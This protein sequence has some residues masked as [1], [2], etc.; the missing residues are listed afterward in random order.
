M[1]EE[2]ASSSRKLLVR[3]PFTI[4][5]QSYVADAY[6]GSHPTIDAT[7]TLI[8]EQKTGNIDLI[9][10][11]KGGITPP[12]PPPVL[13]AIINP[14][15]QFVN[16]ND[17]VNLDGT[18]S[19]GKIV[20]YKWAQV[21]GPAVAIQNATLSI[22]K[23]TEPNTLS[24][25]VVSLTVADANTHTDTTTATIK[26]QVIPPPGMI[27]VQ[28]VE[29]TTPA[30]APVTVQLSGS[31]TNAGASSITLGI[32]S[33]PAHGTANIIIT[34]GA[35]TPITGSVSAKY[36]PNAGFTGT[37]TFT[38][39]ASDNLG[40]VSKPG[41]VTIVVGGSHPPP[42]SLSVTN[43]T[44][45]TTENTAVTGTL[46]ATDSIVGAL[47][48]FTVGTSAHGIA[49]VTGTS[50]MYTPTTGFTGTDS[51]TVTATDNH[52][53]T[54]TGTVT[55][56][57]NPTS[58][59]G[60][61][62]FGI[63]KIYADA[64]GPVTYMDMNDPTQTR[65][66]SQGNNPEGSSQYY[67]N[68]KKNSDGSWNISK[69]EI[70]WAWCAEGQYPGD[71]NI[72]KCNETNQKAG[73]MTTLAGAAD[74]KDIEMTAY[75]RINSA[76][77]SSS[78]GEGHVEHVM[79]GQ[80]STTSSTASGPGGCALGCADNY[81]GNCYFNALSGLKSGPARQKWE[82][83][84]FHTTG[85][86]QDI[87]GVNNNSAYNFQKGVWFGLKTI[88]Y[89]LPDGSVQLEHWTDETNTN[90]WKKTHSFND[91]G[92]WTPRGAIGNCGPLAGVTPFTW[93]GPLTVFRSDNLTS[94][95]IKSASIRTI[96]HTNPLGDTLEHRKQFDGDG[97]TNSD[98]ILKRTIYLDGH[99]QIQVE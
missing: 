42:P 85:Y 57:V 62:Q 84:A 15:I 19:I 11:Q 28:D 36:T 1:V 3:A 37:D 58:T 60:V 56:T 76:S 75:Y 97:P 51:F 89:N 8:A 79:R 99:E 16:A 34:T 47:V 25:I 55:V 70:R 27:T 59:G 9:V 81:H 48:S 91:H 78:N 61:D 66:A 87:S 38:Y 49:V 69:T 18:L 88:V 90:T 6:H 33:A 29:A 83:D 94:Y 17:T 93:G 30:G 23:F 46:S 50:L 64:T 65:G 52:T 72:C 92:Q 5:G 74:W 96:D 71:N 43:L 54:A 26:V 63:K 80:R 53:Q 21:S 10:L 24:D 31:D 95:D 77:T 39:T 22:A 67:P 2:D 35:T 14:P 40:N 68:F 41:I 13:K 32:A 20:S 7:D 82:R 45:T 12:P 44:L 4:A 98:V 86:S 73:Q